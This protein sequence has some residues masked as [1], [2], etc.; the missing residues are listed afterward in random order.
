MLGRRVA[1]AIRQRGA[2]SVVADEVAELT[3]D[4]DLVL[5]NLECCI[6]DRGSPWPDPHKPFFFRAPP[7]A[8]DVLSR[9]GVDCVTLANNHALDFG[10]EALVDTLNHLA[11]AQIAYVG[12]GATLAEAA[13]PAI[14]E[15]NGLR[16]GILGCG[17][18]PAA[19]AATAGRPGIAYVDLHG[20][21]L[22]WLPTAIS[23]LSSQVDIVL[24]TPHWGPNMTTT[25]VPYVRNAA[26]A[27]RGLGADVIA[28]HSA[29]VFHRVEPGTLYDLGDFVDDYAVDPRLRNDLGLLF[30]LV[31]DAAGPVRVEAV[32][33]KLD[34][35]HTRLALGDDA[36]W[37]RRRFRAAC[38]ATAAEVGDD[39]DR[40]VVTWR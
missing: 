28:G 21:R 30:F 15:T 17:D 32:P 23:S 7:V 6:S 38:A 24:V 25:P 29:H 16:I 35:C 36:A 26:A 31:L 11:S 2:K 10:A 34:Y 18:H 14:L 39:G 20:E 37:I 12:A 19:F 9:L 1:D 3:Q 33:L 22:G 5:L 13:A 4:A 40:L 27:I 8:I